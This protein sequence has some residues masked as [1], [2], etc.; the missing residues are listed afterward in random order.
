MV[1]A[2]HHSTFTL[3]SYCVRSPAKNFRAD[4]NPLALS[5]SW[6]AVWPVSLSVPAAFTPWRTKNVASVTMKLGS[7]VL[8]TVIPLINPITTPNSRTSA[9]AGQ[10]FMSWNVV[11]YPSSSPELPIITPAERANSPPIINSA[12]GTATMPYWAAWSVHPAA[13]PGSESQLTARAKYANAKKTASAPSRAPMSGRVSSRL[14]GPTRTRRSSEGAPAAVV[15]V[16]A[17][18]RSVRHVGGGSAAAHRQ[19]SA[20]A[21]LCERR[22][23]RCVRLVDD[24]RPCQHRLPVADSVE[25]RR[26]Q[27]R[28]DDRQVSLQV[29]LLVDRE[30]HL[31]RLDLLD[32]TADVERAD[33]RPLRNRRDARDRDVGIETEESVELLVGVEGRLHLRLRPRDVRLRVR[34]RQDLDVGPAEHALDA[35]RPLLQARVA[36]LVDDDQHLLGAGLLELLPGALPCDVLRLPDVHLVGRQRVER[37]EPG[38]DGDDLD[39]FRRRLLEWPAKCARVRHRG[40]DDLRAVGDR[41]VD[42]GHLLGH[43]VVR[44]DLRHAHTPRL[45]VFLRLIDAPLEHRPERA[46]VAVRDDRDLD[47]RRAGRGEGS[48]RGRP[49]RRQPCSRDPARHEQRAPRKLRLFFL[50]D[51]FTVHELV[52]HRSSLSRCFHVPSG[53]SQLSGAVRASPTSSTRTGR[54]SFLDRSAARATESAA[55]ASSSEQGL[56][57]PDRTSSTNAASSSR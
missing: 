21:L 42:P 39:P 1:I 47:R 17:A 38:V 18:L 40:R 6:I 10:T 12:T 56:S 24:P 23:L 27:D 14:S 5:M 7:F 19:V 49:E 50:F 2:I 54:R 20:S 4:S 15:S 28:E 45:Q 30:Q 36:R 48:A 16:I 13:I 44:I 26:I 31:A 55:R 22:D 34:D 3:K 52:A 33:L 41:G 29:L 57:P 9:I 25:V 51:Q 53:D 35:C 43:V 37:T 8:T 11:R 46:G 32:R